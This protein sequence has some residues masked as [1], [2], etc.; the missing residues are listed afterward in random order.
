MDGYVY[1]PEARGMALRDYFAAAAMNAQLAAS[2]AEG[3]AQA[4]LD[5]ARDSARTVE[6][7]IAANAYTI[8][9]AMLRA[10][11]ESPHTLTGA[12]P[13]EPKP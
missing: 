13:W 5:R 4:I 2:A 12:S 3:P 11:A 1:A 10:R 6:E 9:D 8:A 7:Q